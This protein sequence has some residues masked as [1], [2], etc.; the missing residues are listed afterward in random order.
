MNGFTLALLGLAAYRTTQLAV[1]DTILDGPR[2]RLSARNEWIKGLLS[3]PYCAG[4]WCALIIVAMWWASGQWA[5]TPV[6]I[7]GI[8]VW[9][10]AGVQALLNQ[11]DNYIAN[12]PVV[13][14]R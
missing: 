12:P 2:D 8:E 10:V 14:E 11:L 13:I 3:C 5:G 9:A 7:H 6:L 1:Y 4:F